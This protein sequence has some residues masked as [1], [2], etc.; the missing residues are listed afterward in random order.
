M[1]PIILAALVSLTAS[2]PSFAAEQPQSDRPAGNVPVIGD[3]LKSDAA[4]FAQKAMDDGKA[5]VA[6]ARLA[7][8]NSENAQVEEFANLMIKDHGAA[9]QKLEKIVAAENIRLSSKPDDKVTDM[10]QKLATLKGSDFD[11]AYAK[12]MAEDHQDA[13]D[14]FEDYSED[15]DNPKLKDFAA[16][17]LPTLR[18]HLAKAKALNESMGRT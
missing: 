14:L 15:G 12:H 8:R 1:R 7:L 4:E 18:A 17:T 9:N 2:A 6:L 10:E 11:R 13:V 3:L 5:E 16:K